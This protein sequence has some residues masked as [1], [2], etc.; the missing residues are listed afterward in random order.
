MD[1]RPLTRKVWGVQTVM[2]PSVWNAMQSIQNDS[3]EVVAQLLQLKDGTL[4]SGERERLERC[5]NMLNSIWEVAH[6]YQ[7][8]V[9]TVIPRP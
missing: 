7:A 4:W 9:K 6:D 8:K 3:A 2:I 1:A 5:I